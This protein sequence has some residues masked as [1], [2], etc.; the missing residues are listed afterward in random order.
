MLFRGQFFR[1]QR[2]DDILRCGQRG[3]VNTGIVGGNHRHDQQQH[4]ETGHTQRQNIVDGDREQLLMIEGFVLLESFVGFTAVSDGFVGI[5]IR[6]SIV[7]QQRLFD[8]LKESGIEVVILTQRSIFADI[9]NL[10]RLTL[11]DRFDFAFQLFIIADVVDV[12]T[13]SDCQFGT[14]FLRRDVIFGIFDREVFMVHHRQGHYGEQHIQ[15][16]AQRSTEST[17]QTRHF[18]LM[19][20][21]GGGGVTGTDPAGAVNNGGHHRQNH[22]Q[23]IKVAQVGNIIRIEK[24]FV[25]D[26]VCHHRHNIGRPVELPQDE[27]NKN[28]HQ[29]EKEHPLQSIS[30]QQRQSTAAA[31]QRNCQSQAESYNNKEGGN[32]QA[33]NIH[34]VGQIQKVDEKARRNGGHDHIG[35]HF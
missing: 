5:F 21:A 8:R 3:T 35:K 1:N 9:M 33:E 16:H 17:E 15:H 11:S 10:R 30:D 26:P 14:D 6:R 20:T 12:F 23:Q 32:F 28:H 2:H 18:L 29:R 27:D 19:R 24:T 31:D 22:G 34:R 4:K 13:D 25:G 7:I